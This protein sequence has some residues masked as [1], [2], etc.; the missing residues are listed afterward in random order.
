MFSLN[1]GGGFPWG[2]PRRPHNKRQQPRQQRQQRGAR[3]RRP[4]ASSGG[5]AAGAGG[6]ESYA[7]RVAVRRGRMRECGRRAGAAARAGRAG[8]ATRARAPRPAAPQRAAPPAHAC[9]P[10]PPPQGAEG[11]LKAGAISGGLSALGD[12]LAQL[13]GAKEAEVRRARPSPGGHAPPAPVPTGPSPLAIKPPAPRLPRPRPPQPNTPPHAAAP[14]CPAPPHE[15]TSTRP[16][17]RRQACGVRRR[18]HAAHAGLWSP[19]VRPLPVLL[20]QPPGLGH[21]RA[22][23]GKLCDQGGRVRVWR[24]GVW[25]PASVQ[26]L[27]LCG[28]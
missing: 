18:A 9:P 25:A 22:V 28:L 12:L 10:A 7:K 4:A 6:L 26:K 27:G 13:L 1:F 17:T 8:G 5:A 19:V 16:V 23:D 15:N 14:T 20:V 3:P 24:L 11:P 2:L 21:A